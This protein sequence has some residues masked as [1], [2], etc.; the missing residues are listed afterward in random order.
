MISHREYLAFPRATEAEMAEAFS[1]FANEG[2]TLAYRLMM[3]HSLLRRNG[4]RSTCPDI[5]AAHE[6][7]G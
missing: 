4:K 6:G 2:L 7:Q 1:Q 3:A 5:L